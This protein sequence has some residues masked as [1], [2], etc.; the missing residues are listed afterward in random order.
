VSEIDSSQKF[1]VITV[2][3]VNSKGEWQE[4][5]AKAL[6][7]FFNFEPIKYSHYRRFCG[8]EL[9]LCPFVWLPLCTILIVAILM[10]WV[11]SGRGISLCILSILLLAALGAYPYRGWA[12]K[13]FRE[14]LSQ[15]F[16]KGGPFPCLIAHSFGT[17]LS[18]RAMRDL[19]WASYDRMVLAGCVLA[20]NFPWEGLRESKPQRFHEVRNE[21]AARDNVARL[22]AW[23]D[24]L[25]PGFGSAGYSGFRGSAQW[26][27]NVG[28]ANT[29]CNT[30]DSSKTRAPIHNIRCEELGHS[31]VF[32]GPAYAVIYW[33]PF[34]WGYDPAAYRYF[35]SVCF[36]ISRATTTGQKEAMKANYQLLRT[37]SWGQSPKKSLNQEIQDAVPDGHNPLEKGELDKIATETLRFVLLGQA[38]FDDDSAVERDKYVQFLNVYLAIDAA[39]KK[40]F[41]AWQV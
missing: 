17:Y 21:M 25:I 4:E 15:K 22:A 30:C 6:A 29:V 7:L 23:L 3:G 2:H 11:H 39:W 5:V 31:D 10:G 13:K 18:G 14:E 9:V 36:D 28:S 26:V 8:T 41:P 12:V 20:G 34:L 27:H 33:L 37:I 16:K 35:L 40:A 24:R 38:A 1:R 32:L 19:S